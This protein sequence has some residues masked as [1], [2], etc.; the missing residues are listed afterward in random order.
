MAGICYIKLETVDFKNV[1]IKG[2]T[3][4]T[5]HSHKTWHNFGRIVESRY[6]TVNQQSWIIQGASYNIYMIVQL[7]LHVDYMVIPNNLRQNK[8]TSTF[9]FAYQM[10]I[11]FDKLHES[12]FKQREL[13]K[14]RGW[15]VSPMGFMKVSRRTDKIF[16]T[17]KQLQGTT[18][19][20]PPNSNSIIT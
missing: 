5:E 10:D 16:M 2:R 18:D 14:H 17:C 6:C 11:L 9:Y 1:Q 3:E 15:L 13:E 20:C 7:G 4:V 19:V 12:L 8:V